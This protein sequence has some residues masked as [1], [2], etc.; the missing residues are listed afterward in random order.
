ME[1]GEVYVCDDWVALFFESAEIKS[2]LWLEL[3][4]FYGAPTIEPTEDGR[5]WE[6]FGNWFALYDLGVDGYILSLDRFIL[7]VEE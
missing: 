4:E 2:S 3:F 5:T 1:H 6:N 7:P